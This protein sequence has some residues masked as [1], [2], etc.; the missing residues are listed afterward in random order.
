MFHG[1]TTFLIILAFERKRKDPDLAI[2]LPG[3]RHRNPKIRLGFGVTERAQRLSVAYYE[4]VVRL[5]YSRA[6]VLNAVV[7]LSI[8][9]VIQYY[10]TEAE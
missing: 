7:A 2:W 8:F 5:Q 1:Y 10:K 4:Y 3:F 6:R 9:T